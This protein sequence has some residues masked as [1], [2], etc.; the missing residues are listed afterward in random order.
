MEK[1][2]EWI[3]PVNVIN[4]PEETTEEKPKGL[5]PSEAATGAIAGTVH[6]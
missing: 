1:M 2:F 6:R 5:M 3:T 4:I